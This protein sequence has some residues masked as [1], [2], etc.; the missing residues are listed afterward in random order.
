MRAHSA[1]KCHL[2]IRPTFMGRLLQIWQRWLT[3]AGIPTNHAMVDVPEAA[4]AS[5]RAPGIRSWYPKWNLQPLLCYLKG[6]GPKMSFL[7]CSDRAQWG[8]WHHAG[9]KSSNSRSTIHLGYHVL[10][11]FWS[12]LWGLDGIGD[13]NWCFW[14]FKTLTWKNNK[15]GAHVV[16]LLQLLKE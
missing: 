11:G 2:S 6:I 10:G 13:N 14:A 3:C 1:G 15:F 4:S 9:C 16:D 8:V 5:F 12:M 7:S